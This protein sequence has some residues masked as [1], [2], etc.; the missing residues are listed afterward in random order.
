LETS[1]IEWKEK[2]LLVVSLSLP[3]RDFS[4]CT[5]ATMGRKAVMET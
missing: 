2:R 5:V 3:L 4:F 1:R